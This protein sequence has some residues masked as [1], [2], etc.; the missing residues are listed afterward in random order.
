MPRALSASAWLCRLE[1]HPSPIVVHGV[2]F[3]RWRSEIDGGDIDCLPTPIHR[4]LPRG[5]SPSGRSWFTRRGAL[6]A[7]IAAYDQAV[8]HGW[9]PKGIA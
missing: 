4:H 9:M 5:D 6:D 2:E 8:A 7:A 3:W 1:L